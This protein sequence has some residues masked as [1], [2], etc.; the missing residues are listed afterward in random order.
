MSALS[1]NAIKLKEELKKD[2]FEVL[3]ETSYLVILKKDNT[4]IKIN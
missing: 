2:G 4:T 1:N 3:V